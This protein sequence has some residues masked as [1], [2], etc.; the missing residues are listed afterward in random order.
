MH[1]II[2]LIENQTRM[3]KPIRITDIGAMNIG[4]SERW[5]GL[6]DRGYATLVGFE[7]QAEECARCNDEAGPGSLYI[8]AALGDGARWPFHQCRYGATSSIYEPN[9]DFVSQFFGLAEL[10]EVIETSEIKTRR[11]D[12]IEETR[13]TDFLKIDVQ[14]AE[15]I[16]LENA[17]ETLKQVSI[18]Q[19]EVNFVPLYKDQPFFAE[20]DQFLRSQGFMLH[21]I[22]SAGRRALR[23]L[24]I[25]NSEM[26]GLNQL[27]WGDAVYV[28]PFGAFLMDVSPN[29][30]LKRAVLFH[31]LFQS[32]DFTARALQIYDD[33]AHTQLL[34]AY[35]AML[36]ELLS[37]QCPP[38]A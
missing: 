28:R 18:I 31:M 4:A 29:D 9:I 37:A 22:L 1:D 32:Y 8:P 6:I 3:P 14:G 15:L 5:Q 33:F 13:E 20:V 26:E 16:I 7:P 25:N 2:D 38:P 12:D 10:M 11:L 17:V 27:L 24:I 34:G 36:G 23:P 21:T 19:T 35:T 30:L